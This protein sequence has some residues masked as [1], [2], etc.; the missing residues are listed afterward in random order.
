MSAYGVTA[1]IGHRVPVNV[2][3]LSPLRASLE[4]MPVTAHLAFLTTRQNKPFTAAGFGGWFRD[5]CD[6][7][8]LPHCSAHGLRKAAAARMADLGVTTSELMAFFGWK[9]ISQAELYTRAANRKHNA[10]AAAEKFETRTRSGK[11]ESQFANFSSKPL[12]K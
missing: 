3:L 10:R 11:P 2:P 5:R 8:G 9:S 6:D 12:K 4:A 1:D 7:A